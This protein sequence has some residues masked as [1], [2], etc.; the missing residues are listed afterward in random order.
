MDWRAKTLIIEI[1]FVFE[2][3]THHWEYS[4]F[5]IFMFVL[6]QSPR[7][8]TV[9]VNANDWAASLTLKKEKESEKYR[10]K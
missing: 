3:K 5:E 8:A 9:T 2:G 7:S 6:R 1:R 4:G 10:C